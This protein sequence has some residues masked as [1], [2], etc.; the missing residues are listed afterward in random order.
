MGHMFCHSPDSW[1][2]LWEGMFPQGSIKVGVEFAERASDDG[3]DKGRMT[4]S[5]TRI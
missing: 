2:E 4:W 1:R 5:V 3:E